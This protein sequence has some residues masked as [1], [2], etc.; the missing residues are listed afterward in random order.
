M[1]WE[2]EEI[3]GLSVSQSINSVCLSALQTDSF[4]Y[5]WL[6]GLLRSDLLTVTLP[7]DVPYHW[8]RSQTF[9]SVN[10]LWKDYETWSLGWLRACSGPSHTRQCR[11]RYPMARSS[12]VASDRRE[13]ALSF[14][15][16]LGFPSSKCLFL[17]IPIWY[18]VHK[19]LF[20]SSSVLVLWN[21][22][23]SPACMRWPCSIGLERGKGLCPHKGG[24]R[25]AWQSFG[26]AWSEMTWHVLF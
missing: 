1:A 6:D 17:S 21:S 14:G 13:G 3:L 2:Y 11:E 16:K 19:R 5:G 23:W 24:L 25:T 8:W 7:G 9:S 15:I 20:V 10:L 4:P 22:K 26:P 18:H 12:R